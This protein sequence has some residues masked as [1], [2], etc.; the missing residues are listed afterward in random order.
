MTYSEI[1]SFT[2]NTHV[3]GCKVKQYCSFLKDIYK[4]YLKRGF[5]VISIRA[6]L[7][8][9]AIQQLFHELPTHPTLVL[10]AQGEHVGPI[11]RNIQFSKEKI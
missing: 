5:K 11:E 9:L 2:T 6:D 3:I 8:F 10:A 4:M 1:I 7:K